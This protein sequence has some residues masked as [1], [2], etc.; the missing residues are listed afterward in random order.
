MRPTRT[1]IYNTYGF[2][3]KENYNIPE[4]KWEFSK[5]NGNLSR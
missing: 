1:E 2:V 5:S 3:L 4:N